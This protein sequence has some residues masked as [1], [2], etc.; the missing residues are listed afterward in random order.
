[1]APRSRSELEVG[2]DREDERVNG[3]AQ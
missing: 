1:M 2:S 3:L